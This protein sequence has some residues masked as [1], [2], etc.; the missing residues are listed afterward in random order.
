MKEREAKIENAKY[1]RVEKVSFFNGIQF[2]L[3][4]L[5]V[6][7]IVFLVI[8][9]TVSYN[10]AASGIR[11]TYVQSVSGA[12]ELTTSYYQFVFDSL[13]SDYNDLVME[14]KIRTYVNGGYANLETTDSMTLYNENYKE[15]NY[16]VTDNKF[17]ADVYLLTDNERSITTSNS[18]EDNL[19]SL[20]AGT[21]QGEIVSNQE[22]KYHYLGIMPEVDTAMK[23]NAKEY[24][25]RIIRK[26]PK[27]Q[28][29]LVLDLNREEM[30]SLLSQLDIGEGSIVCFVTEDGYEVHSSSEGVE[31]FNAEQD[32]IFVGQDYYE[33]VMADKE[34]ESVQKEV[35]YKGKKYML[36]MSKVGDTGTAV[37]CLIPISTINAQASDIKTVTVI[38]LVISVI[39][40]GILGLIIAQGMC[41][42]ISSIM[43]QIKKVS[44]GDLTVEVRVRRKDE[45]AILAASISDMIAHTKHLIQQ[46]DDISND[47]TQISEEVIRSSEEFLKSSKGIEN[48]VG[49]IDIG[50]NTQA[51]HAVQCLGQMD[52]LSKRI[53]VVSE[54]TQKISSIASQTE[55]SI[56]TGMT[57]M[58]ALNE[59]SHST[60]EITNVVIASIEELEVKSKSIGQIVSAINEIASET[61]LLSLN[62]SI[63]AARA[64]EAGRG[65]AVVASEIRKLADQSMESANRIHGIINEIVM[66]TQNAVNTA[67][68]AD[69]IVQEQQEAVNDTTGAFKTMEQQMSIL[70]NELDSILLGVE[71]MDKTRAATLAAIEEISAVSEQTAASATSV[72]NM[73][74][75]QLEGVEE[76]NQNSEKL[77][78][79]AEELGQAVSQ[80]KVR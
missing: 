8:L 17:L 3:Y 57:S 41:R 29:Y 44:E 51:E 21:K 14:S 11:N 36:L 48:S 24:A 42:T 31:D 70:L 75:Q 68:Q 5:I 49:E 56:K 22:L 20:I 6:I 60:A 2:K 59:K 58:D 77:S 9:G 79:S 13:R 27:G 18:S 76:L 38:L 15:F 12:I 45:F 39:V 28:G 65:F 78:S 62:A 72:T 40:S 61:N 35:K 30:E 34:Q 7:P 66:T 55:G 74:V 23:A 32:K 47:L 26:I 16:N 64:G 52:T 46:V 10:K 1:K 71:E 80:F 4:S 53:M 63:E 25:I 33:E 67:K 43:K 37:C 19:Y 54:N 73:V 69:A 50:T